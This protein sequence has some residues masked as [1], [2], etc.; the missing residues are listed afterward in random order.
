MVDINKHTGILFWAEPELWCSVKRPPKTSECCH[1]VHAVSLPGCACW[2]PAPSRAGPRLSALCRA[3][4]TCR[5]PLSSR[6]GS[7]RLSALC[8]A[9]CTCQTPEPRRGAPHHSPDLVVSKSVSSLPSWGRILHLIQVIRT[10]MMT[11]NLQPACSPV[12]T[13]PWQQWW[14]WSLPLVLR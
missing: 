3:C 4:C 10:V 9:C 13:L 2:L 5:P 7:R 14:M 1:P 8:R 6:A 11:R 12:L